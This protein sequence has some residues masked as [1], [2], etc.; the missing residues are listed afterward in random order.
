[1]FFSAT[2]LLRVLS[3]VCLGFGLLDGNV[4]KGLSQPAVTG[5]VGLGIIDSL[6]VTLAISFLLEGLCM[7]HTNDLRQG[8]K[9]DVLGLGR[10]G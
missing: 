2:L 5:D 8:T 6:T 3:S 1:M 4:G 9:T 7:L 10:C